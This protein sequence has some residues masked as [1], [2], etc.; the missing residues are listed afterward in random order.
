MKFQRFIITYLA[1][2]KTV[3]MICLFVYYNLSKL[4]QNK[5][6]ILQNKQISWKT[7]S[8]S[9]ET[10]NKNNSENGFILLNQSQLQ[11]T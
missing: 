6:K 8:H 2:V 3:N 5:L 7:L 9:L 10:F 1:T 4:N 11:I